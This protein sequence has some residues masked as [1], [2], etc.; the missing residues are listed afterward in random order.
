MKRLTLVWLMP[1]CSLILPM[2]AVGAE[3]F[4]IEILVG[5]A[6][7]DANVGLFQPNVD[8][9]DTSIGIRGTYQLNK[10]WGLDLSYN[11]FGEASGR[12]RDDAGNPIDFSLKG[13]TVELNFNGRVFITDRLSL[14]ARLGASRYDS[15]V[16][17]GAES[18]D[19]DGFDLVLG[20]AIQYG[21]SDHFFT[22]I[23]YSWR[24]LTGGSFNAT[25]FDTYE[26][27]NLTVSLGYRF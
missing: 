20:A 9:D 16:T 14:I 15:E 13:S 22:S 18:E 5:R 10:Y 2:T 26:V 7:H 11:D 12:S 3:D 4:A 19:D 25:R 6:K 17:I 1:L 27:T 23:D 24:D 8:G 21:F